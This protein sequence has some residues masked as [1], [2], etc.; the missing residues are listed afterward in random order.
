ML[1]EEIENILKTLKKAG[2][3][4]LAECIQ[5]N[6]H[7]TALA[8]SIELN[9]HKPKVPLEPEMLQAFR[10]ELD[11]IEAPKDKQEKILASIEKRRVLQTAPHLG[12][13]E[14]PACFA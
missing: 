13:T 8:Y 2:K 5:K 7:K 1:A 10:L 11:R 14:S 4:G 12:A 3:H 6:W 9:A